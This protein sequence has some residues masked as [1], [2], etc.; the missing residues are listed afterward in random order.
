MPSPNPRINDRTSEAA[1]IYMLNELCPADTLQVVLE[2]VRVEIRRLVVLKQVSVILVGA[3][4]GHHRHLC[5][6]AAPEFSSKIPRHD[7]EL[8]NRIRI[9]PQRRE[10]RTT[11]GGFINIDAVER[12]IKS[13]VTRTVNVNSATCIRGPLTTSRVENLKDRADYVRGA[14]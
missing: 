14:R 1:A 7:L 5:S 10:V 11:C 12:K 3:R 13:P 4:T 2:F 9:R 8:L 6:A